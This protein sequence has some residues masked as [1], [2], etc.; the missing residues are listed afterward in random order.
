MHAQNT[1]TYRRHVMNK[2]QQQQ[3]SYARALFEENQRFVQQ[4]LLFSFLKMTVSKHIEIFT[5]VRVHEPCTVE[6]I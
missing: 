4:H 1:V 5:I 6:L 2:N 3:K